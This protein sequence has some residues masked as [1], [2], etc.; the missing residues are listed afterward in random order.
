M[1]SSRGLPNPGMEPRFPALQVDSL[2]SEPWEK[3]RMQI[4]KPKL[5]FTKSISPRA[6]SCD[7]LDHM[8]HAA[9]MEKVDTK[10]IGISYVC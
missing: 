1:P 7:L 5:K 9:K 6:R 2:P 10:E 3:P 4:P 8:I